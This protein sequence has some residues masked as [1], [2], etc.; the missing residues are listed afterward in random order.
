MAAAN[1]GKIQIGIYVEIKRSDGQWG[2]AGGRG[3]WERPQPVA[4]YRRP[5]AQRGSGRGLLAE[6]IVCVGSGRGRVWLALR[7]SGERSCSAVEGGC[8]RQPLG[9]GRLRQRWEEAGRGGGRGRG[10]K[11]GGRKVR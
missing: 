7:L 2:L 8:E 9:T 11:C 5:S 1:F 4:G 10:L 6:P 3:L